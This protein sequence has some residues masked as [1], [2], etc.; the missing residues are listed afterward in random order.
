LQP[1]HLVHCRIA[2]GQ[3]TAQDPAVSPEPVTHLSQHRLLPL[4]LQQ[5]QQL[6]SAHGGCADI[7][8]GSAVTAISN[9]EF[10]H[11]L[12]HKQHTAAAAA[13]AAGGDTSQP[14][15]AGGQWQQEDLVAQ[16]Y[17]VCVAVQQTAKGGS[18]GSSSSSSTQQLVRCSYLVAA[19]GAHSVIRWEQAAAAAAVVGRSCVM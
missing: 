18:A 3:S 2:A 14:A 13:A 1:K 16:E 5:A 11:Q 17:P 9:V 7:R 6:S 4:L 19:D 12:P 15:S 10:P 8:F